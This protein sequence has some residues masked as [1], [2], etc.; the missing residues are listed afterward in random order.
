[1]VQTKEEKT[2]YNKLYMRQY[3]IK[4][5]ELNKQNYIKN[6]GKIIEQSRLYKLENKEKIKERSALYYQNN[7]EKIIKQTSLYNKEYKN[8]DKAR[9]YQRISNWKKSGILDHFNDNYKTLYR[10][11][12]STKFCENC[13]VELNIESDDRTRKCLDH[14]HESGY[15]RNILCNLC[16][17]RRG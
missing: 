10:I 1:M 13:N 2:E 11:Y 3:R 15:F 5:K 14:S 6:K 8:T 4:N 7:K 9:N 12:L 16:N 17:I